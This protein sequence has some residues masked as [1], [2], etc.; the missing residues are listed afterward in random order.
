M[1]DEHNDNP[2]DIPVEQKSTAPVT[3]LE[4]AIEQLRERSVTVKETGY[5]EFWSS[6]REILERFKTLKPLAPADRQRLWEVYREVCDA[7][8]S[9]QVEERHSLREESQA[10]RGVLEAQITEARGFLTSEAEFGAVTRARD[11]LMAAM[12]QM[13]SHT[14]AIPRESAMENQDGTH[15]VRLLKDDREAVWKQWQEVRGMLAEIQLKWQREF[16]ARAIG[17]KE[18]AENGEPAGI[19]KQI[20]ELQQEIFKVGLSRDQREAL[21]G[22]LNDAWKIA[23]NRLQ[24]L[25]EERRT[26]HAEWKTRMQEN[27]RRWNEQV[28]R[29]EKTLEHLRGQIEKLEGMLETARSDDHAER[30]RGWMSETETKLRNAEE[31]LV[32]LREKI[33]SV[34]AKLKRG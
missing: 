19:L 17:L 30:V 8:H 23:I 14:E 31:T 4:E 6:A 7:V 22:T 10:K 26:R 34:H 5:R 2:S 13:K 20:R 9:R 18:S 11:L 3:L 16:Q 1:D 33:A 25:R 12:Q 15:P 24:V 28:E 27:L 21:R 29:R 32:S